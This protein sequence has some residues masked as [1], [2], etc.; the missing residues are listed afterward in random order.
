MMEETDIKNEIVGLSNSLSL[1]GSLPDSCLVCSKPY[2]NTDENMA[3]SWKVVVMHA[4]AK[5][6]IYCP[7]CWDDAMKLSMLQYDVEEE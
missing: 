6:N 1:L 5:V 4:G 2:D 3:F 7:E